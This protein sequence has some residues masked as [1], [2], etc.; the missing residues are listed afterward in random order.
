MRLAVVGRLAPSKLDDYEATLTSWLFRESRRHRKQR[1]TAKRLYRDLVVLG[2][3][4]SYDRVV[5]FARL[6]RQSQRQAKGSAGK[7]AYV[8]LQ[9]APGEA[10]Q[11]DWSE[12]WVKKG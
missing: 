6:W 2:Y 8:P 1:R 9:F 7:H 5:A 10:F 11:F 12:D 3:T 4:G